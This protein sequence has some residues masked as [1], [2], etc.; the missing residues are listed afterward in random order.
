LLLS[1]VYPEYEWLP[2]RFETTPKY[3]WNDI[4]NQRKF[5]EWL[6]KENKFKDLKDWYKIT[7]QVTIT[8]PKKNPLY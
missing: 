5:M 2:W 6:Q 3:F 7:Y 1:S 8:L 4:S